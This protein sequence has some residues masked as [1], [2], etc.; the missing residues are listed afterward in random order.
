MSQ[1]WDSCSLVMCRRNG[2]LGDASVNRRLSDRAAETPA[3][4]HSS[5]APHTRLRCIV[6][7]VVYGA[8][9]A[10]GDDGGLATTSD[11]PIIMWRSSHPVD[12]TA[13]GHGNARG[14][15][16][17]SSAVA[18]PR[19]AAATCCPKFKTFGRACRR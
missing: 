1:H 7:H 16:E 19:S 11:D 15:V 2:R 10:N 6:E 8:D 12:E 3:T 4:R 18:P 9:A 14:R 13:G 17:I 5:N